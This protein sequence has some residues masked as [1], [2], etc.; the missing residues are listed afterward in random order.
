MP[1]TVALVED[2]KEIREGLTV[3]INGSE[4]FE[5]VAAYP[6]AEEALRKIESDDPDVVMMDI[7][8]P[9]MSGIECVRQLK[10]KL[11]KLQIMMQT[12]YEDDERIFDSLLA[13][14]SGY[15]LKKT[16]PTKFL[17]A[18]Q[19]LHNGGSPMSSQIARK[20]VQSFQ[21]LGTSSK[22]TENL[23]SREHEILSLLAKGYRYKEIAEMLFISIETVRTHLRNIYEKLQV[24]SR[25][26]AV[27]KFLNR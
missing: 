27:L 19:D 9:G 24:R 22:E 14:A 20:V 11:P 18:I 3:L 4:G 8:L 7:Q 1:I 6:T 21:K 23:T 26:E 17:E 2:N 5:C 12:I 25:T 10:A 13:G 15:I 16:P